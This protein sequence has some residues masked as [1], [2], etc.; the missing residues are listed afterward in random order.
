[1]LCQFFLPDRDESVVGSLKIKVQ[2]HSRQ[3]RGRIQEGESAFALATRAQAA[4]GGFEKAAH[5]FRLGFGRR[6]EIIARDDEDLA[7]DARHCTGRARLA[8]DQWHLAR[9]VARAHL[10]DH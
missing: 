1:M 3:A 6:Q 7:R 10:V 4:R 2:Q 9:T 8:G 5:Q